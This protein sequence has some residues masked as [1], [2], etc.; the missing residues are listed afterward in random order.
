MTFRRKIKMKQA[1]KVSCFVLFAAVFGAVTGFGQGTGQE[2]QTGF[3][4]ITPNAPATGQNMV[5]SSTFGNQSG[6]GPQ[7][8]GVQ[9]TGLSTS[10]IIPL[11]ANT[12]RQRDLG[13]AM[14]NLNTTEAQA[15]FALRDLNGALVASTTATIAPGSHQALFVSQLFADNAAATAALRTDFLGSLTYQSTLPVAVVGLRFQGQNFSTVPAVITSEQVYD[16]PRFAE[17]IGGPGAVVLPQF[18]VGQGWNT[19]I[20]VTNN[21]ISQPQQFRVDLFNQSGQPLSINLNGE[22]ASSFPDLVA[23]VSGSL[24]LTSGT[25]DGSNPF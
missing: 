14:V 8:A 22:T 10:G 17:G 4:I 25:T 12:T 15:T 18:A 23:P 13:V 20:A 9:A 11:S 2:L 6:C 1:A 5:V 24:F 16:V 19:Q 7:A 21:S 3:V